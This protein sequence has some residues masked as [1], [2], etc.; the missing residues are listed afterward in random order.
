MSAPHAFLFHPPFPGYISD[1]GALGMWDEEKAELP[2]W[3]GAKS[4]RCGNIDQEQFEAISP[5]GPHYPCLPLSPCSQADCCQVAPTPARHRWMPS[6][7]KELTTYEQGLCWPSEEAWQGGA[8]SSGNSWYVCHQQS[9]SSFDVKESLHK[10]QCELQ[11][12]G[13]NFFF[14]FFGCW[15]EAIIAD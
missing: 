5:I 3:E 10:S 1:P 7:L 15:N 12:H 8:S 9:P 14:F 6:V 4:T 11:K 13:N 2:V